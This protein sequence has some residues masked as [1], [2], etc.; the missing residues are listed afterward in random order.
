MWPTCDTHVTHESLRRDTSHHTCT[1]AGVMVS[2]HHRVMV[3]RHHRVMVSRHH[4]VALLYIMVEL[5]QSISVKFVF[6]NFCFIIKSGICYLFSAVTYRV[7][8]LW[9]QIVSLGRRCPALWSRNG[10]FCHTL[11]CLSPAPIYHNQCFK[12]PLCMS[13]HL[14]MFLR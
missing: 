7:L 12:K 13:I 1:I 14:E 2:R 10:R 11:R 8:Y 6:K 5:W 4:R 9:I 3:S